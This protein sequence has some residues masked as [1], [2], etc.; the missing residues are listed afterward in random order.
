MR[1]CLG[2]QEAI[3]PRTFLLW[4][5]LFGYRILL[6][7]ELANS[8]ILWCCES[9]FEGEKLLTP[10]IFN[11]VCM[12]HGCSFRIPLSKNRRVLGIFTCICVVSKP[13]TCC[14]RRLWFAC[15]MRLLAFS[16]PGAVG[17][18]PK[19]ASFHFTRETRSPRC[20]ANH[21]I[22]QQ[23]AHCSCHHG[24]NALQLFV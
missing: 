19:P 1:S 11:S 10:D 3:E 22:S 13:M 15:V 17:S 2:R 18:G 21:I 8:L 9:V 16:E 14:S 6:T 23:L 5:Q 7:K 24:G 12:R 20:P 4:L